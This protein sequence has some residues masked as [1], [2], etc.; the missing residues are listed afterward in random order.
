MP[1]YYKIKAKEKGYQKGVFLFLFLLWYR[2]NYFGST[3]KKTEDSKSNKPPSIGKQVLF[4][5]SI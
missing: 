4:K 2:L 5:T 3:V 1:L